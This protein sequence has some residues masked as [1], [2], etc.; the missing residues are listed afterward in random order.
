MKC[1]GNEQ[2]KK[3]HIIHLGFVIA[4]LPYLIYNLDVCFR[5]HQKNNFHARYMLHFPVKL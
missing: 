3:I 2:K 1:V 5:W 4:F